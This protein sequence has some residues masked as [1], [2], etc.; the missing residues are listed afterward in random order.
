MEALFLDIYTTFGIYKGFPD[1]AR[2]PGWDISF[3]E[4][5]SPRPHYL[6]RLTDNCS[7]EELTEIMPAQG[8]APE[9]IE[10]LED[11]TFPA[12]RRKM[13]AAILAGKNKKKNVNDKKKRDR[14]DMKRRFCEQLR[15]TQ[16]Y[17][18]IRPRGV[19]NKD[20]FLADP[21]MTYEQSLA[22]Q[23]AYEEAAGMRPPPL[24]ANSQAPYPFD[25]DVVFICVDI[26]AY[27]RDHKK[28]TEIGISTLDTK[29]VTWITPGEGGENWMRMIRGRHFRIAEYA[30][31]KN[32]D[33][34]A[35]CADKFEAK[36]GTS[37][38]ISIKEAPQVVASC[39][40]YP[41]S[42][43]GQ[44]TP[45]PSDERMVGRTGS[46]SRYLPPINDY[47]PKRNVILVGHEIKS[48]I[49]YLRT[50]GYDVTNLSNLLEAVDTIDL[51]KA[52]KHGRDTPSL[53]AVLLDLGLVGWNL[54]NAV[55]L[56]CSCTLE[57][58][59]LG[60]ALYTILADTAL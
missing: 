41:Y 36:F 21:N 58:T 53:G 55:S 37:E 19:A 50:I 25:K 42:A 30:H 2:H 57:V 35:G 24:I 22:A 47:A 3:Q 5:G 26:E 4:E 16:C 59:S 17:L 40:R 48:D 13:E 14:V 1:S 45:F 27:E 23:A 44:Y 54:H 60:R 31:L 18:G 12:F 11:R 43:P 7:L 8:V 28:I 10:G 32:T 9:E 39:F 33:F 46:G 56:P 20:D 34:I 49:E 6:G 51:F 52:M 15:R 29:D 38:W